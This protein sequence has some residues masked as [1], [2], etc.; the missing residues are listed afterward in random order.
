MLSLSSATRALLR[1]SARTPTKP[2]SALTSSSSST[3]VQIDP[4]TGL[5]IPYTPAFV[6]LKKPRAPRRTKEEVYKERQEQAAAREARKT[7]KAIRDQAKAEKAARDQARLGFARSRTTKALQGADA[8]AAVEGGSTSVLSPPPPPPIVLTDEEALAKMEGYAHMPP[9][10]EWKEAFPSGKAASTQYRYFTANRDTLAG[11]VD[12]L[13]IGSDLA[14]GQKATVIEGYPGPGTFT[15][16]LV[17]HPAVE[18]VIALESAPSYLAAL[19]NLQGQLASEGQPG[20]LDIVEGSAYDWETYNHMITQGCLSHLQGKVPFSDD[21]ATVDFSNDAGLPVGHGDLS[22]RDP[23]PL[24]FFAHLPNTVHG[25]QLFA[26]IIHAIASRLWL[27]R[28]GRLRL[29]FVCGEPLVKRCMGMAG[30][31]NNRGKLGTTLQCLA[32]I[33]VHYDSSQLS[34]HHHHF[35]PS[36][37]AIGPRVPVSSVTHIP[38]SNSST[39]LSRTGMAM[40]T[41]TPKREPLFGQRDLEAF[42]FVT[43]NLFVLKSK[44]VREAMT[45]IAPGGQNVLRMLGPDKADQGLIRRDEVIDP[46]TKVIDLTNVQWAGLSRTFEKWPFRPEHLFEM[47][48]MKTEKRGR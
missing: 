48:R 31:R 5:V 45:H 43:R 33:E 32:D 28:F 21:G 29:G 37:L 42:E 16:E 10:D 6:P 22:W 1:G 23:S 26:Q 7:A 3:G 27:F 17:K 14:P 15:S 44:S 35:F 4:K 36:T 38:N 19:R 20:K 11:M 30:D 34:P 13:R 47:G 24:Y 18:K 41:L 12:A 39:G 2:S 46:E 8:D 9:R 40:M 25:E